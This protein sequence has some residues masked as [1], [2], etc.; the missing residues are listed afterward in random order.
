MMD[1]KLEWRFVFIAIGILVI[2]AIF[3]FKCKLKADDILKVAGAT[4]TLLFFGYKLLTGWLIINLNVDL[5]AER[6]PLDDTTDHLS[7]SV[8]LEKGGTDS[9]W[10][11]IVE[12]RV[13]QLVE[14][15]GV[16][17]A[18]NSKTI[19]AFGTK[20]TKSTIKEA[21]WGD[22]LPEAYT[23]SPDESTVFGAYTVIESKKPYLIEVMIL[24][25]RPFY[26]IESR[27]G[28]P[29]Q[30]RAS[31]IVLPQNEALRPC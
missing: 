2:A 3:C 17:K 10:M 23:I 31:K 22:E 8:K 16:F 24:G 14:E 7:L 11:K 25:T 29:I 18:E 30:W 28:K 20:K 12:L 15:G 21:G 13:S 27:Q 4:V 5:E 6:K 1:R 9:V 19:R 26:G